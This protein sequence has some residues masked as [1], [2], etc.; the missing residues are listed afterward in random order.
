MEA[1][2]VLHLTTTQFTNGLYIYS[3]SWVSVKAGLWSQD[4]GLDYGL[5]YGLASCSFHAVLCH[6]V[7]M[8]YTIVRIFPDLPQRI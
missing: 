8:T 1:I 7:E 4:R 6:P 3:I 5:D 2:N